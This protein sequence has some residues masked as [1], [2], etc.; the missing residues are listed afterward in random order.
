MELFRFPVESFPRRHLRLLSCRFVELLTFFG[1]LACGGV[2][3]LDLVGCWE[4]REGEVL[5]V[6]FFICL[7]EY[8]RL[9]NVETV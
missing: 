1:K 7:C 4:D 5:R 6:S 8:M 9:Q 3:G 2:R